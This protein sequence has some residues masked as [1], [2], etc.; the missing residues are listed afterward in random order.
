MY[1]DTE[2]LKSEAQFYGIAEAPVS[3]CES[4]LIYKIPQKYNEK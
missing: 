1:G 3:L 4:L 2:G